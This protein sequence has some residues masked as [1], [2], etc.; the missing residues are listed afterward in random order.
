MSRFITLAIHTYE[1]AVALR[2]SLEKEGIQAELHN[3]NLE[4]PGFSS[5]VRV[6][7]Q[8]DDLPLAL[9][10][11]ENPELFCEDVSGGQN[12][13]FL[14][15]VD[16]SEHS[17]KGAQVASHI[18][19]SMKASITL[20]YSYINPYI[21]GT[22]QLTDAYT[23][24]IGETGAREQITDNARK[25]MEHFADRL[26]QSMKKGEI[27]AVKI[28]TEVSEGVPEDA[29]VDYAKMH[30]PHLIVMGT[31]SARK[32]ESEMIGSITAE[33]LDEGRFTVLTV[34]EPLAMHDSLQPKNILF[35]SNIDQN[36]ILAMDALYRTF[37]TEDASVTIV[38][39]PKKS[40]FSE[41]SAD[42][43]LKRL[44]DYCRNNFKHYHFVSVPVNRTRSDEE[45]AQLQSENHFDLVVLPNRRRNALSRLINPGLAH[46]LLF[47]SDIPMLVIPV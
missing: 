44:S 25:I 33:V 17:F 35:F 43:A 30:K 12:R 8:E 18:A 20:L 11:V 6:R 1:K 5:G 37:G 13:V 23:Y 40:R 47:Q 7:I 14:V 41:R 19:A 27:P 24:E 42:K 38:H 2:A 10:V 3:V 31:R 45:F 9:R 22:I 34:P 16:F 32:K 4:V 39:I 29:I 28:N 36:D 21:A 46:R 15:P 26:R